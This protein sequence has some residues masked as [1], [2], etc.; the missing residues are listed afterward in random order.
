MKRQ[1]RAW[2]YGDNVN[3]D[4]I[5]PGK[6]TYTVTD[7]TLRSRAMPWK[8]STR[9]LSPVYSRA[10]SSSPGAIGAVDRV[11]N[12]PLLAWF[13]MGSAPLSPRVLPASS[14]VMRSTVACWRL[15]AQPPRRRSNRVIR[16]KLIWPRISFI[17]RLVTLPFPP[18]V[19]ASW[20]LFARGD[21]S[22]MLS[23]S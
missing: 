15:S 13:T 6:Y 23:S 7:Q 14:T 12:R 2:K 10:I 3:T 1:G 18:L 20:A 8:I 5:F 21:S 4:V 9:P 17:V 11:A 16:L 19:L 22:P